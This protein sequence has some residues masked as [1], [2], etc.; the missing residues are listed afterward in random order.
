MQIP[1][2]TNIPELPHNRAMMS[3]PLR[4]PDVR[5]NTMEEGNP[6][7]RS[8][9]TREPIKVNLPLIGRRRGN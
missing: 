4:R 5:P 7:L 3:Y 1:E 6:I 8:G 9:E 2:S